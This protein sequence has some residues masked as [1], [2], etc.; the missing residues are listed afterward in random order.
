MK[1]ASDNNGRV[2]P[3]IME[4]MV[5]ANEG[6]V[7]AYGGDDLS[8][9]AIEKVRDVFEAPEA[10]VFLVPTGTAANALILGSLTKPWETIF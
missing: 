9:A 4:A 1:F 3:K 2:H 6:H 5:R 10:S 7:P 8:R